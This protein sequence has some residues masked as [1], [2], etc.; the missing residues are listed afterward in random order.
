M[1]EDKLHISKIY[2]GVS[3]LQGVSYFIDY[4]KKTLL[5]KLLIMKQLYNVTYICFVTKFA[6]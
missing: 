2:L 6:P 3:Y 4:Y 5:K 1:S